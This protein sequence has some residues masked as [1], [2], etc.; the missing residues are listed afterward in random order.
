MLGS[1][2]RI[3]SALRLRWEFTWRFAASDYLPAILS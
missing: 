3:L 2:G 1:D